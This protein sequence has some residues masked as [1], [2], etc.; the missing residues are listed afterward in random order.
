MIFFRS[1]NGAFSLTRSIKSAGLSSTP[2]RGLYIELITPFVVLSCARSSIGVTYQW[3]AYVETLAA[4]HVE[5]R[6]MCGQRR[7]DGRRDVRLQQDKL[8]QF[9]QIRDLA[10]ERGRFICP[11]FPVKHPICVDADDR[12]LKP[13][14]AMLSDVFQKFE[15]TR[16]KAFGRDYAFAR[17]DEELGET[18]LPIGRIREQMIRRIERKLVSEQNGKATLAGRERKDGWGKGGIGGT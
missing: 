2:G 17:A 4:R 9:R 1:S 7:L 8:G 15:Q 5:T 12:A 18:G 16:G 10:L 3:E 13:F 6:I 11:V 14:R